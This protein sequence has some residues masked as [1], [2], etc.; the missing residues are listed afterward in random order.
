MAGMPSI[1]PA[2]ESMP[3]TTQPIA[4]ETLLVTPRFSV[5]RRTF[6]AAG[7]G[8]VV[9]EFVIHPGAVVILPILPDGRVVMVRQVRRGVQTELLELPAGTLEPHE[10]P[11]QT[12]RRELEEE[13]G[14]TAGRM[15]PLAQFFTSPGITTELMHAFVAFDLR[16]VGQKLDEGE[17][18]EV[19]PVL[20]ADL[21]RLLV[22]GGLRDGKTIAV[23]GLY[24][25]GEAARRS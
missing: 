1:K 4:A 7:S 3:E 14:Y 13:T 12:A 11:I 22:G 8:A 15:E 16:T 21:R 24:L 20:W 9:R 23:L 5:E 6:S 10:T 19:E 2:P 17:Q 18:L 25:L